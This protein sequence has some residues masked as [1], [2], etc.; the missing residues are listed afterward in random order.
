MRAWLLNET[1]SLA[2][3]SLEEIPTPTVAAQQVL[4]RIRAASV[5]AAD[6]TVAMGTRAA[7]FVHSRRLPLTPGFDFAGVVEQVG[8]AVRGRRV[9]DEVY[10]F[11]PYTPRNDRGTFAEYVAAEPNELYRKPAGLTFA[12]AAAVPTCGATALLAVH[13]V[14]DFR[15]GRRAL[16]NGAS[17]GVGSFIVQIAKAYGA[18]VWGTS[19]PENFAYLRR[20]GAD[21]VLDYTTTDP[22][23]LEARFA[24]V[25]DVADKWSYHRVERRLR[26]GGAYVTTMPSFRFVRGKLAS[27][28]SSKSCVALRVA[29]RETE[30]EALSRLLGS[31][32]VK[33]PIHASY[34]MEEAPEAL[35][36]MQVESVRGKV[37]VVVSEY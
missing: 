12:E 18:E 5:N 19:R 14:G 27:V 10:G 22:S 11:L 21:Q 1:G 9:G 24:L 28:M 31:R 7:R 3:L 4:V 37:V 32:R 8:S 20:I 23:S 25:A 33:V 35:R 13:A 16:I 15:N 6:L 17:G 34:S 30:L 26:T 29:P 36:A 2:S